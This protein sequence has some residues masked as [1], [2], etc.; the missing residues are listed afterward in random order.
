MRDGVAVAVTSI[1]PMSVSRAA[2]GTA[3]QSANAVETGWMGVGRPLGPAFAKIGR[4]LAVDLDLARG[5]MAARDPGWGATTLQQPIGQRSP[6]HDV[7]HRLGVPGLPLSPTITT[8]KLALQEVVVI[9][10]GGQKEVAPISPEK[11]ATR[12][13][14]RSR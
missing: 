3:Y 12:A 1:Q 8:C 11:A 14:A 9:E 7:D 6:Q 13:W 4:R 10:Q 5:G 2:T